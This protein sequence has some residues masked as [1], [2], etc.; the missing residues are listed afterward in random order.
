MAIELKGDRFGGEDTQHSCFD[1]LIVKE[2]FLAHS[3]QLEREKE[4][5]RERKNFAERETE[6]RFPEIDRAAQENRK[7]VV[8]GYKLTQESIRSYAGVVHC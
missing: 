3:F 7:G 2:K 1:T 5:C 8:Q 4:F 6:G